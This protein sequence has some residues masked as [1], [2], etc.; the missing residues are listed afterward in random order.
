MSAE[1]LDLADW[2]RSIIGQVEPWLPEIHPAGAATLQGWLGD[3]RWACDRGDATEVARLS[4]ALHD[5]LAL[6]LEWAEAA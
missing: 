3:L 1:R 4:E 5:K 6:E 2:V